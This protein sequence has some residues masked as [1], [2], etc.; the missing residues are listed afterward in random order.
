MLS[1]VGCS[2][3][4]PEEE[5]VTDPADSPTSQAPE[6][7]QVFLMAG[8][9][10]M[11]GYG[12]LT[13][14]DTGDWPESLSLDA[15]IGDGRAS[16]TLL[17]SRQDVWVHFQS[18]EDVKVPG[19]LE[20]GF[21]GGEQFFGPALGFGEVL[22]SA[23]DTPV[24]CFKSATGGTTLGSDWLPPSA[25]V[26]TGGNT[27]PLYTN[28][29]TGFSDFLEM[30]LNATFPL[31]YANR[32]FEVAGFVWLQGW[33]DQFEDGFVAAYEDNLVDLVRD[34]RTDLSLPD[35]PVIIVEGPTLEEAL[36]QARRAAMT[37]LES[38]SPG[39]QT[40]IE[41]NDLVNIEVEGNFHFNFNAEN[42]LGVGRRMG[43]AVVDA[44]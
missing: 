33:N 25:A 14:A 26:R 35:L 3:A 24:V 10:N 38:D 7:I 41:T 5:P 13:D 30:N 22:G 4:V 11:V 18:S 9:S 44:R 42:Y 21:G 1:V 16:A 2:D 36:R 20:P 28:M 40:F 23:L 29:M 8:Q 27:G 12:P 31:E 15:M 39:L 19:L 43:Q 6:P 37:R 17:A 34:V 32:G